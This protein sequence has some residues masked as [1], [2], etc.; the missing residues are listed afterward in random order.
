LRTS[1]LALA[2]ALVTGVSSALTATVH[3][4]DDGAVSADDARARADALLKRMTPQE[5]AGQLVQ[6]FD[7]TTAPTMNGA[8]APAVDIEAE[9]AKGAVGSMLL[10]VDPLRNT[11]LQRLAMTKTRLKI[12]LL[13]GFD[14]IHGLHTILPV[15]IGMAASWDP[16]TVERG[17]AVAA[18]E[19]RAVG[20][21]WTFAPMVDI[22]QD[23]RWGRMVEGAGEDPVLGSAMAAAQVRGFQGVA[24]GT[25][26]RVMAGPKHFLGYG[27]SFGG[28]DY[29]EAHI[30]EDMLHNAYLKPFK[31]AID[32]GAGNVMSAYMA[33]NA[34]PASANR[35]MLTDVLRRDLG[36]KGMVVSDANGVESLVKQGVAADPADAAVRALN[37]GSEMAMTYPMRSSPMLT[38]PDA[39]AKGQV[40]QG[41]LDDAVR[42]VL[43]TKFRL[44]L[45]DHPY[46]DARAA[47]KVL[48]D[49]AHRDVARIAAERAAVLLANPNGLLPLDR[50][51]LKSVAVLGPLGDSG[52]DMLGPWV[53]SSNAPHGVSVVEGLRAKLGAKVAVSY[54]SGV[55]WPTRKV[56]SFFDAINKP[57]PHPAMDEK[58]EFT[59]ALDLARGADVTVMVL[60]EALNMSGEF[61][62]RSDLSLPGRQQELLDAVIATGKPVVVVLVNGRPLDLGAA[63]PGA[64]LEAWY[65]GSEGGTAIANLLTGDAV[66]G[67]KLPF[68]WI[69]SAAHA[70][71][72]YAYLPSHQ[73]GGANSRYWNESNAPT[74]PFGFGLSYTT[75]AYGNLAVDRASVKAG[76][77]VTVSFDLTN[78]GKRAGDEVAQLYIHQRVGTSSRPVRELKKFERLALAPGETR[79]MRFTLNADDLRYWSDATGGW[80]QDAS[81]FDVWVGGSSQAELATSFTVTR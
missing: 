76:E 17:Q 55:P 57:G 39:V 52:P 62:S 42:H 34:V 32:A 16:A 59:H 50:A 21:A 33:I 80:V 28:R 13:F 53:F 44:G 37:A 58:A 29:D 3:A 36:F 23:P 14:V 45:F 6:Y 2:F 72:T 71:Y 8:T 69:R 19:A 81:A 30:S 60:G 15:P 70:P 48:A 46:A 75:F 51:A 56:P 18:A 78:T 41:A 12:P 66:P 27:A 43:E 4:K 79:H 73:P 40:T 7:M 63:K 65:P 74:W 35:R 26:G 1:R 49:P 64:V 24:L 11:R 67:G 25:P 5:K 77:P 61:A 10:V 9:V 54:A 20:I 68:S 31:A 22:T 38:L 47:A